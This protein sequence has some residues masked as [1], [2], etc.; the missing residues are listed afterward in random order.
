LGDIK[1]RPYCTLLAALAREPRGSMQE[2][3]GRGE[4]AASIQ[5]SRWDVTM[6]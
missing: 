1:L 3:P 4:L 5:N 2:R 6:V